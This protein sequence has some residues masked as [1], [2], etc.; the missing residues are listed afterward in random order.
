MQTGELGQDR[1]AATLGSL[2]RSRH[3]HCGL[4]QGNEPLLALSGIVVG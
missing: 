1:Q 2:D 4:A 3:R